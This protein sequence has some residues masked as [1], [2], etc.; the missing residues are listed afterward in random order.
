MSARLSLLLAPLVLAAPMSLLSPATLE[1]QSFEGIVRQ[2][3]VEIGEDALADVLYPEDVE[4]PEFD[5]EEEWL[6]WTANRVFAIQV[7]DFV[8]DGSAELVE[9]T[10]WIKRDR[11]RAAL[12]DGSDMYMIYEGNTA[13]MIMV[14]PVERWY[15][16]M[17]QEAIDEVTEAAMEEAEAMAAE[18]GIDLEEMQRMAAEMAADMEEDMEMG[19]DMEGM[20]A[21]PAQ[22]RDLGD[23]RTIA[24]IRAVGREVVTSGEVVRAWCAT[25]NPPFADALEKMIEQMGFDEDEEDEYMGLGGPAGEDLA[26]EDRIP[27][28]VQTFSMY[29]GFGGASYSIEEMISIEPSS[30][31]D[32][33]FEIPDGFEERDLSALWGIGG[34]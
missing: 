20:H 33:K 8:S 32:E 19:G 2:R 4:E 15:V 11:F 30:V 31:D 13:E 21:A 3:T 5:T 23:T 16:R 18:M 27:L 14:N 24:G 22:I 1:A 7:Q 26:C 12:G 34:D 6:A 9:T 10:V 17:S 28:L 25:E 29:D